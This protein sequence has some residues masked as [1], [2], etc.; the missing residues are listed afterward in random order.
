LHDIAPIWSRLNETSVTD[1]SRRAAA[2]A[3]ART[4]AD[5]GA[6]ADLLEGFSAALDGFEHGA[7]AD[8]V[9]QAGWLEVFDD[10][11][12]SGFLLQFVDEA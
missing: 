9:A 6:F 5:P 3:A 1:V 12:F 2:A 7:F 4:G 11:P 8:L 10:R